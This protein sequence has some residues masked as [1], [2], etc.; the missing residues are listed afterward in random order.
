M[1]PWLKRRALGLIDPLPTEKPRLFSTKGYLSDLDS[2]I[3]IEY[4]AQSTKTSKPREAM[5]RM[6]VDL[7]LIQKEK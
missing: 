3:Q 6:L 7:E 2:M 4:V 1:K 5:V